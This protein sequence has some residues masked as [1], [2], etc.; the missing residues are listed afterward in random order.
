MPLQLP[1]LNQ[2]ESQ[3]RYDYLQRHS[4]VPVTFY[5]NTQFNFTVAKPFVTQSFILPSFSGLA[6]IGSNYFAGSVGAKPVQIQLSLF[7]T[8]IFTDG[9]VDT[10]NILF[11][12]AGVSGD[13]SGPVAT[14][15]LYTYESFQPFFIPLQ[16]NSTLYLHY[17][18]Y[19]PSLITI[20]IVH[21]MVLGLLQTGLQ[22]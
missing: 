10:G 20:S 21:R 9:V 15:F 3:A 13:A 2:E 11:C 22:N 7:N 17:V 14:S 19:P 12:T 4:L 16:A 18:V 5:V 8:P 6:T 1:V